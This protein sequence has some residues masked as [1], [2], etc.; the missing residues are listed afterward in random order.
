MR[1]FVSSG[2][3]A[4]LD[5]DS[6]DDIKELPTPI[7]KLN[8][9][10][11]YPEQSKGKKKKRETLSEMTKAIKGFTEMAKARLLANESKKQTS[12]NTGESFV[13]DD[14]FLTDKLVEVLN[15]YDHLDNFTHCK[16]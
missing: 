3:H 2:G 7:E 9:H 14:R 1:D 13:G 10:V 11:A 6:R 8:K 5:V 16:V 4:H 12:V 15:S